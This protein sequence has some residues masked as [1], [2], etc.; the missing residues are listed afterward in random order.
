MMIWRSSSR[1]SGSG[2]PVTLWDSPYLWSSVP[3]HH[4]CES[5]FQMSPTVQQSSF[6]SR[7]PL[8]RLACFGR[9]NLRLPNIGSARASSLSSGVGDGRRRIFRSA[10]RA[11]L[12]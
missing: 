8:A 6:S 10:L 11:D 12:R 7:T 2:R 5:W 1:S 4:L 9:V 3:V